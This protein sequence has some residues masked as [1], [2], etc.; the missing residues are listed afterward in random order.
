MWRIPSM[1]ACTLLLT[2]IDQCHGV[3]A[4]S[5]EGRRAQQALVATRQVAA[6]AWSPGSP[7]R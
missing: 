1:H 4:A 5:L 7:A 3:F 2:V 6:T